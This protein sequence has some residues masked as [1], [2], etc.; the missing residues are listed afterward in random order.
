MIEANAVGTPAVGYDIA[1][2]P[3]LDP[4][5]TGR[6]AAAGSP[7]DL[8]E[9]AVALLADT[10]TYDASPEAPRSRGRSRSRWD[11]TADAL[12]ELAWS[13]SEPRA[14]TVPR[15]SEV[16]RMMVTVVVPT[17][18]SERTLEACLSSIRAQTLPRQSR[19]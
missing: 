17:R 10:E 12:L 5:P 18:D 14:S 11:A 13:N 9:Q 3:R 19:S 1:G 4:G 16:S 8:A 6:L 7:D 2:H 15:R